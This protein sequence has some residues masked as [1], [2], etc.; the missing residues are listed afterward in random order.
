MS[1]IEVLK[2]SRQQDWDLWEVLQRATLSKH[3]A[4]WIWDWR[5]SKDQRKERTRV[6]GSGWREMGRG[7]ATGTT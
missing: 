4:K 5:K 3:L 7:K 2:D 6:K 1:N